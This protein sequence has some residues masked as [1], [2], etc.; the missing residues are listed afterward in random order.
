MAAPT[1]LPENVGYLALFAVGLI[2]AAA[3]T[4][5]VRAEAR[6]GGARKTSE[7]FY[8]AGRTI[9]TGLIASSIV[10]AW[11]WAATLLQSSTVAFEFGVAGAFWYAAGASIQVILFSIL[12]IELKRKAPMTHTF[13]EVL[14]VRYGRHPHKVFLF[15]ALLTNTVVT[16]MLVLGGAAV[17]NSL[18]GVDITLA[19]FL[20]PAGIILYTVFGGLKAT[21]FAEYLNAAFIF[22]VVLV[23]VTAIYFASPDIGGVPGMYEKLT[24]A[25]ALR[26]VEGNALGSYLTLASA[27]A[28]VFGVINIVGNFGTVFVDQSYWQRAIAARP[29]SVAGGFLAGGLAWFAIPFALAT[30][31]GLAAVA[32]GV[33]LTEDE[34]GLGLVAPAAASALMGDLGAILI[35]TIVFTAVTAAGSSQLVSVSSLLTYDV[36]RTYLR[37]S[38]TGRQLMRISR[39]AILSFGIGMG[40]L[41]SFL[42][43]LGV[44][45][46]YVYLMMG[47]LIGPAVAPI[48]L[49]V[50]WRRANRRAATA[51]AVAGLAAGLA[52]WTG[53]AAALY[54]EVSIETTGRTAA[55][56]AGNVAS[57]GVSLAVTLA[58]SAAFP[59]R[60]DFG[61]LRQKIHLVDDR[62][63]SAARR[64]PDEAGLRR[65]SSVCK[66]AGI[67]VTLVLVVAW[68]A[69]LYLSGHVFTPVSFA[70]WI[71]LMVVWALGSAAAVTLLPVIEARSG[72][73]SILARAGA[74]ASA[75]AAGAAATS[76]EPPPV[77]RL[78]VALD[79][80]PPSLRALDCA[81]GLFG[82]DARARVYMLH[83][84]RPP[85]SG[86]GQG[87]DHEAMMREGRL[88]LRSVAVPRHGGGGNGGG[89][90][91]AAGNE[92]RR[93]VKV[94]D[95]ARVIAETADRLGVDIIVMGRSGLDRRSG[96]A[97]APSSS[98]G[99]A[100]PGAVGGVARSV[101][102]LTPKPVALLG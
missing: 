80:S 43:Q 36:Y 18:T 46:Q 74:A 9:K 72:I 75:A 27:G 32:T 54:G 69:P 67:G 35:L 68:P 13:P 76:G 37:P 91:R 7:W 95:P 55:L 85:P 62:V 10:S 61:A 4:L 45:L 60:F 33:E 39:F 64:G 79:G 52:A 89:D 59:E 90:A 29:R 86:D 66:R 40:V 3:V 49:G 41:A 5:M 16:A 73:G 11:T 82:G 63:R 44:G 101:L 100:E 34:V 53:A 56:L 17:V 6:W 25:A 12:A 22:G 15:F 23:F 93:I 84:V 77:R 26:P 50:L 19:A 58:G 2:M 38:A 97:S 81:H 28:L 87:A 31:L 102:A 24:E 57:I 65:A 98:G 70:A 94:G 96:R 14:Y 99:R 48:S 71:A 88:I 42:F 78:L 30:T 8:T 92:Y 47:I 20:L 83:V 51:A 1:I 21:F